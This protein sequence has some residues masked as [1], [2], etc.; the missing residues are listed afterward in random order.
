M[1]LSLEMNDVD[2]MAAEKYSLVEELPD[3]LEVIIDQQL[4]GKSTRLVCRK[5][6]ILVLGINEWRNYTYD[7]TY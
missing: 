3:R 5:V 7:V 6:K 4:V 1:Q 2:L